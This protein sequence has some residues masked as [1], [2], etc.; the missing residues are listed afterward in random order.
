MQ[1]TGSIT[2]VEVYALRMDLDGD[3]WYQRSPGDLWRLRAEFPDGGYA[4]S[5]EA[6]EREFGPT[7]PVDVVVQQGSGT[8]G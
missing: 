6:L 5:A 2:P 8:D 3:I 7:R 1:M 4:Y